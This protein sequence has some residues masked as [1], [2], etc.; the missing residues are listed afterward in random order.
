LVN[1]PDSVRVVSGD[2]ETMVNMTPLAMGW[3]EVRDKMGFQGEVDH[4]VECVRTRETPR[5]S[6]ADALL[7]HELMDNILRRAGLPP[8]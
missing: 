3:A 2:S 7:T 4:F 8:M 6:G 5:T 1:A